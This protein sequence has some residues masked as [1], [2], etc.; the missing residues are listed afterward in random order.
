MKTKINIVVE[1]SWVGKH[2]V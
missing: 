2:F 1:W